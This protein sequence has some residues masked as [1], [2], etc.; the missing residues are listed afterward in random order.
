KKGKVLGAL[1]AQEISRRPERGVCFSIHPASRGTG[2]KVEEAWG[3]PLTSLRSDG[4]KGRGSWV[5]GGLRTIRGSRLF[6]HPPE[7]W[8][9]EANFAG[10]TLGSPLTSL[11]SDGKKGRGSWVSGG[12]RTIRGS[13][14]SFHPPAGWLKV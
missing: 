8:L 13:R 11:R 6:F 5:S 14:L 10:K 2:G 3:S 4:K 12:L 7:G 9:E 1:E